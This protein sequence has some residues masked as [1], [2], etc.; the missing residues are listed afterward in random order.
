MQINPNAQREAIAEE[1]RRQGEELGALDMTNLP[2]NVRRDINLRRMLFGN[3]VDP[4]IMQQ[5]MG[6][7]SAEVGR[8]FQDKQ[9]DKRA[10][11]AKERAYIAARAAERRAGEK[12]PT[13]AQGKHALYGAQIK[14]ELEVL[15]RGIDIS[16]DALR[17]VQENSLRAE[18]ADNSAAS[19]NVS[20]LVT[21]G[22]RRAELVPASKY[23]GLTPEEQKIA[24][25]MDNAVQYIVRVKTGAGMPESEARREAVQ[26][27]WHAGDSPELKQQ[28]LERLEAFADQTLSLAGSAAEKTLRAQR[29]A[30]EQATVEA[31]AARRRQLQRGKR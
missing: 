14:G 24:N 5:I 3:N 31:S 17:K 30:A 26:M 10:K 28:K 11:E 27:A 9:G 15:K 4:T 25:A 29:P 1:R 22:L 23:E 16:D 18:A 6:A 13:E 20:A 2:E 7:H 8:Q 19:G 12:P 21:S